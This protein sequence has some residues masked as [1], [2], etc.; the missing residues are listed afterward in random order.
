MESGVNARDQCVCVR[1]LSPGKRGR[2]RG[3]HSSADTSRFRHVSPTCTKPTARH[4]VIMFSVMTRSKQGCA[5]TAYLESRRRGVEVGQIR[6]IAPA[7]LLQDRLVAL[8]DLLGRKV[9]GKRL[10][11]IAG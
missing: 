6:Q 9:E 11:L 4:R 1:W 10:C 3:H 2:T 7:Q 8:V 5:L